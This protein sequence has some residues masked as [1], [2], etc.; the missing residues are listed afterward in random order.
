MMSLNFQ[1]NFFTESDIVKWFK[2]FIYLL[3]LLLF[4]PQDFHTLMFLQVND[5]KNYHEWHTSQ[6][7][8]GM[9]IYRIPT[10]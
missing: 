10:I 7:I 4:D 1:L 5:L 6:Y 2:Y 8:A 9:H 3:K